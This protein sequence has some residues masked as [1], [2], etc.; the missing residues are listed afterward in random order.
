MG[1][2]GPMSGTLKPRL[3]NIKIS[4]SWIV[5]GLEYV[6]PVSLGSVFF[7]RL[8]LWIHSVSDKHTIALLYYSPRESDPNSSL[9]QS[10]ADAVYILG[11]DVDGEVLRTIHKSVS[12]IRVH[13]MHE[14]TGDGGNQSRILELVAGDDEGK[15]RREISHRGIR[16]SS[17]EVKRH[18]NLN[19][20]D[21]LTSAC[22]FVVG[23][24]HR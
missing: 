20:H 21:S 5:L 9:I 7:S 17:G 2:L 12:I 16:W 11:D 1:S 23:W 15:Q 3:W 13:P 6:I 18:P 10:M 24:T 14:V 22:E 8:S 4:A 19:E